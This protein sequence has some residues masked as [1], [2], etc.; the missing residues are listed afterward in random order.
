MPALRQIGASLR[1]GRSF[2]VKESRD[3]K[4]GGTAGPL[5]STFEAGS[6]T[7]TI[8][9]LG[10]IHTLHACRLRL[11]LPL[12]V[13]TQDSLR[14][15]WLRPASAE[16]SSARHHELLLTHFKSGTCNHRDRHPLM[17]VI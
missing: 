13:R 9:L 12:S 16:L 15:V 17:V 4:R 3:D 7:A 14:T 11:V 5:P 2:P 10:P 1:G 6:A 8:P